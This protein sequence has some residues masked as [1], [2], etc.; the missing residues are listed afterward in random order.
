MRLN[1]KIHF[2]Y[3]I[4]IILVALVC[5]SVK[6]KLATNLIDFS[7]ALLTPLLAVIAT[8]IAVQ[9]WRLE[10]QKWRLSL[11]DKRF[12]TFRAVVEFIGL[13]SLKSDCRDDELIEFLQKASRHEFLFEKEIQK[14]IIVIHQKANELNTAKKLIEAP[15]QSSNEREILIN[16]SQAVSQWFLEQIKVAEEKFGKYLSITEK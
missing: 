5:L 8:Y 12:E 9:Q 2:G 3:I 11:Y 14:Y 1:V 16:R 6:E 13:V 15:S 10:K 7:S 4:T